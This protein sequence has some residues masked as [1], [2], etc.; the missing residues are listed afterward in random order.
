MTVYNQ[1]SKSAVRDQFKGAK[2]VPKE[3][4]EKKTRAIRRRLTPE[5]ANKKT[6]KATKRA[7]YFPQ[8]VFAVKA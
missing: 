6:A 2:F 8:R 3:L 4:R 5:Q 1:I 7:A